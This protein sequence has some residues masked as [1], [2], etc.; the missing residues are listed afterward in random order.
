MTWLHRSALAQPGTTRSCWLPRTCVEI[1]ILRRVLNLRID[2]HA[3]DATPARWRGDAGSSPLDGASTAAS[4]P[5]ELSG[6]P[7][8]LVD[9]HTG[10]TWSSRPTSSAPSLGKRDRSRVVKWPHKC[11]PA[12]SAVRGAP[13][14]GTD[15]RESQGCR[16][17]RAGPH[18]RRPRPSYLHQRVHQETTACD[19]CAA[20][21]RGARPSPRTRGARRTRRRPEMPDSQTVRGS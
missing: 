5:R 18:L 11:R 7:D 6:V 19:G 14:S 3:I 12:G 21:A 17:R 20:P 4:S 15:S 16:R 9:F 10:L 2:L 13:S 1:K 8:T